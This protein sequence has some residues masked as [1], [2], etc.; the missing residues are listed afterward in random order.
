[1]D[2]EGNARPETVGMATGTV[3]RGHEERDVRVRTIFVL[4]VG[5]LAVA[6]VIQVVLWF[7][8]R[9][10]WALRQRRLPPP[11]PVATA[12]PDAPPEPRLQTAPAVDLQ[13]LRAA[14]QA[15]LD[16]YGW[17]DRDAGVVRIPIARAMELLAKEPGR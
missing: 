8:L 11:S 16:G 4:G 15:E 9:G 7:H 1:M 10:L 2:G 3:P 14:E 17:V 6:A 13:A 5:F 12:L